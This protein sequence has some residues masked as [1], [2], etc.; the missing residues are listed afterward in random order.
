MDF[1]EKFPMQARM[2][3]HARARTHTHR[4]RGKE[5][6]DFFRTQGDQKTYFN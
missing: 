6:I 1:R 5:E 4:D 3:E 2:I